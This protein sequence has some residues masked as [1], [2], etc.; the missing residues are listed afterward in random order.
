MQGVSG[1]GSASVNHV[2][3]LSSSLLRQYHGCIPLLL[4]T[5]AVFCPHINAAIVQHW[6][7]SV[8]NFSRIY[9]LLC[10]LAPGVPVGVA[11]GGCSTTELA[12]GNHPVVATHAVAIHHTICADVVHGRALVFD[13]QFASEIQG[14]CISSLS[15]VLEPKLRIIHDLTF[16]LEGG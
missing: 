13:L 9:L 4:S 2:A 11:R 12:Y 1:R 3:S 15:I 6:F 7:S 10:A 5:I 8:K 14:L 16:A